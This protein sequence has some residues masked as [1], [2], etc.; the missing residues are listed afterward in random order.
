MKSKQSKDMLSIITLGVVLTIIGVFLVNYL[1][2]SGEERQ[3][4]VE[5]YPSFTAEFDQSGKEVLLNNDE[6]KDFVFP[7]DLDSGFGNDNPFPDSN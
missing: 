6:V 3:E 7:F 1:S 4:T 5:V 2:G